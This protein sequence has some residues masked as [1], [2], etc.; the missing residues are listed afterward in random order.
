MSRNWVINVQRNII[1]SE[2]SVII[3]INII[4]TANSPYWEF[5]FRLRVVERQRIG[6]W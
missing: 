6:L 3:I 4:V 1:I 2:Y 5:I